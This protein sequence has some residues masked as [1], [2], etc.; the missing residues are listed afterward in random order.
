MQA[1]VVLLALTSVLCADE[2]AARVVSITDGDTLV[3]LRDKQQVRIR[4][5]GIDSPERAQPYGTRARQFT[6]ELAHQRDV[7]VVVRDY[8]RYGRVV[9]EIILPDGR[10][11]NYE[12]VRAGFAWWYRQYARGDETLER[13]E[14][15]ARD[16]RRGLWADSAPVPPWQWRKEHRAK[17]RP[18]R[19]ERRSERRSRRSA[20]HELPEGMSL[21]L[22]AMTAA[23]HQWP[24]PR[25]GREV[26]TVQPASKPA[27]PVD[28][29]LLRKALDD[30]VA[31]SDTTRPVVW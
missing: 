25:F 10:N 5:H 15:E 14:R 26:R 4:L 18:K 31:T 19:S 9:A 12:I 7:T 16:A 1:F 24:V 30:Y 20:I 3:V 11:L 22:Q 28:L 23:R 2:F 27:A 6:G 21:S 17:R 8:D 13:L 29:E